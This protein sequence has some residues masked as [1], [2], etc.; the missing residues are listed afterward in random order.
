MVCTQD[1]WVGP[2]GLFCWCFG[3]PCAVQLAA[4]SLVCATLA[5]VVTSAALRLP[6]P[7]LIGSFIDNPINRFPDAFR[8]RVGKRCGYAQ[9]MPNT[10][11]S[12]D[13]QRPFDAQA[14][15]GSGAVGRYLLRRLSGSGRNV[16]ALSRASAPAWS[17][18]WSSVEWVRGGL[19]HTRLA[20]LPAADVLI[21]AGPLDALAE[22]CAL[23]LHPQVKRVVALSSLSIEWK[24]DS[25]N[26]AERDL[27]R[28]LLACEQ[29]L[30]EALG[31]R[32][33]ALVLLRPGMI[34]GAG[35][36]KS[37]SPLLRFASR[38]R[39]L[40][41]P[42]AGRGLRCPVHADDVAAALEVSA[43]AADADSH[44]HPIHLPGPTSLPFDSL[45]DQMLAALA[46]DAKRI[47]LPVP[48]SLLRHTAAGNGR[49]AALAA[50]L[51]RSAQNQ[52]SNLLGWSKLGL[53]PR[54]FAPQPADFEPWKN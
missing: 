53:S 34:Y 5:F 12:R 45:L 23:S 51:Y 47:A 17:A 15:G 14:V 40:P 6:V 19:P 49:V 36:D 44:S 52:Q 29:R 8:S 41:W 35:V 1:Q 9:V 39:C 27:A 33:V 25:P 16:I 38:W 7:S 28:R 46:N 50:T 30:L 54:D 42:S 13:L 18:A 32:G 31:A 11:P 20:D 22:A 2:A 21:S 4:L 10:S 48:L 26:P 3:L 24:W 37:L 43:F